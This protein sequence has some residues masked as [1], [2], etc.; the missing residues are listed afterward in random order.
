VPFD[1]DLG[2][3]ARGRPVAVYS[4]CPGEREN[5]LPVGGCDV[6]RLSLIGGREHKLRRVSTSRASEYAP[7]I[8]RGN[9]AYASA[10]SG[11]RTRLMLLRRGARRPVRV[12]GGSSVAAGTQVGP[13]DLTSNAL[14]YKWIAGDASEL[15]RV[16]LT[17][18]RRVLLA[19]GFTQE[20]SADQPESPNATPDATIW[21]RVISTPC[22]ET[23]IVADH[24]GKR[25]ATAPMPRDIRALARD[26]RTLYAIT[27][28]PAPCSRPADVTLVKLSP[29]TFGPGIG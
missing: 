13:T 29:P 20:G 9:V 25:R 2:P 27:S 10:T 23:R 5:A 7:T 14:V 1:V 28:A 11:T 8:W 26:G 6:Y 17:G 24:Q 3:D 4:R 19:T 12:A 18:A 16:S 22:I 15:W 21:V